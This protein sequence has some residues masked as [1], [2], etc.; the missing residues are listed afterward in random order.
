[1]L[2][3]V[4]NDQAVASLQMIPYQIKTGDCILQGGYISGAMTHPDY[5]GKGLMAQLLKT[6]FDEMITKEYDYTFLIPQEKWLIRMYGKYGFKLCE[7]S[8]Y[9]HENMVLKNLKQRDNIQQAYFNENGVL[10]ESEPVTP[11]E[12]KG[13]IKRLNPNAKEI[14]TLYMGMM[15]D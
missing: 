1:M 5:R 12:H 6:S 8:H 11:V 2:V 10:L 15:L 3:Y 9:P 4:E 7:P 13:M 14:S